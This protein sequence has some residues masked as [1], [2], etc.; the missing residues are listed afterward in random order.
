MANN[1]GSSTEG[2]RF[3]VTK[4]RSVVQLIR[5]LAGSRRCRRSS[6]GS[7]SFRERTRIRMF[8]FVRSLCSGL[9]FDTAAAAILAAGVP[10]DDVLFV[11]EHALY[12]LQSLEDHDEGTAR[13][14]ETMQSLR[15]LVDPTH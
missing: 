12:T 2:E 9:V 3:G 8:V 4:S 10:S 13:W 6:N 14:I 5:A 11:G 15:C 7:T 1:N